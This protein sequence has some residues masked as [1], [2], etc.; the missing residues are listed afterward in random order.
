MMRRRTIARAISIAEVS[1]PLSIETQAIQAIETRPLL[2]A[3]IEEQKHRLEEAELQ[4][5]RTFATE[6]QVR[7]R[8]EVE[9]AFQSSKAAKESEEQI[10]QRA[11][12]LTYIQEKLNK[13]VDLLKAN[14]PDAVGAALDLRVEALE[15]ARSQNE[16]SGKGLTEEIKNLKAE[17]SKLTKSTAPK[18]AN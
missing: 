13:H 6:T 2:Q 18:A 7:G 1:K 17:R 3:A 11:E 12:A 10:K 5:A 9:R 8:V 16:T 14:Y 15:A 4:A